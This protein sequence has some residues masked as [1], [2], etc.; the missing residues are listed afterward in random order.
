MQQKEELFKYNETCDE[1]YNNITK[2]YNDLERN[3]REQQF[4]E[5]NM[6]VENFNKEYPQHPKPSAELLNFEKI[7]ESLKKQRE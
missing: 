2:K 4:K 7:L 5:M 3:L 1:T 6:A